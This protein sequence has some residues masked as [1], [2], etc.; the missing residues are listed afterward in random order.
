MKN[1]E[2]KDATSIDHIRRN[3]KGDV[4]TVKPV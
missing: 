3:L 4:M 1:G 2:M